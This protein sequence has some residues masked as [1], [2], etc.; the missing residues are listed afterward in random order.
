MN[1]FNNYWPIYKNLEEE[2]I[3]LSKYIQFTDDQVNVYSIHI[4]DLLMRTVVEIEALSKELYWINGGPKVFNDKGGIRDLFFDTDCIKYLDD[5]WGICNRDIIISCA[6]FNFTDE[7]YKE[8]KPLKKANRR[9][10]KSA[11]WNRAYQAVKHDRHNNL[12]KGNIKNLIQAL[13][14][15]YILNIYY[16]ND[17][18]EC[19]KSELNSNFFD[20]RLGSDIFSVS[21]ADASKASIGYDDSDNA[22]NDDEREKLCSAIYVVKYTETSWND[23]HSEYKKYYSEIIDKL[24]KKPEFIRELNKRLE[25]NTEN[26]STVSLQ[27]I[28]EMQMDCIKEND[29][30]RVGRVML[31]GKKEA[32]LNKGQIIYNVKS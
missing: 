3:H 12:N 2:T 16:K 24:T 27:L 22:I 21:Y 1:N 6:N 19:R 20:N 8:F 17:K 26:I 18:F 14:A 9:G 29:P 11:I 7:Q 28:A 23:I 15:L 5:I 10:D 25:N 30:G 4:A 13:G 32:V 31:Q